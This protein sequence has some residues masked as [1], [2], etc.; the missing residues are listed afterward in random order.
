[1]NKNQENTLLTDQAV[2]NSLEM[3]VPLFRDTP[4]ADYLEIA[5]FVDFGRGWNK[6]RPSPQ[7][8]D[9]YSVGTGL[10][11]ALTF[12]RPVPIRPQFEFYWGYRL[13][14]VLNPEN[15]LQDH[16]ISL[17]FGIGFF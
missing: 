5:P 3:R 7:P 14:K 11:W 15:S 8:Q 2:L 10:R 16:G 12:L 9:I 1:M 17:Q 6:G 13:R 4:W